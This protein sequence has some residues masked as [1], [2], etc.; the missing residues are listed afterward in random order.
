MN[1]KRITK[2][3]TFQARLAFYLS[4]GFW[5]P[6]F[7]IG[8]AVTSIVIAWKALRAISKDNRFGGQGYAIAALVLSFTIVIASVVFL[9]VYLSKKMT[10]DALPSFT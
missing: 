8:L 7:N 10:C 3:D 1:K 4:L 5:I 6:L 9:A 2:K